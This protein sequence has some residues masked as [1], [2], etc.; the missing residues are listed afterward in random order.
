MRTCA[1]LPDRSCPRKLST[2][3]PSFFILHSLFFI[4]VSY[5]TM[6]VSVIIPTLNEA[7]LIAQTIGQ[8]RAERPHEIIVV[9]GGSSD[10]TLAAARVA[11]QVVEAA[12]GRALQ[13]NAGAARATGDILLFL[14]ADCELERGARRGCE[15]VI[16]Q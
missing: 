15:S 5:L 14:H 11:D 12:R 7:A 16:G 4:P 8:V 2:A 10:G 3:H 13:M 9:D 6:K 1:W